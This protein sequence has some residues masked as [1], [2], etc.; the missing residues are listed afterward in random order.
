MYFIAS[1]EEAAK[2]VEETA[3][4][5]DKAAT[6]FTPEKISEYTDMAISGGLKLLAAIAIFF[7]GMWVSKLIRKIVRNSL[8]KREVDATLVSF[9]SSLLYYA[10]MVAVIIAAIQQI[11]FQTTSLVAILG[12]AGL[13]VG[14]ALQGSLSN[15]ASG[16]LIILFRPFQVGDVI[17][18]AGT[19]GSVKDIG[20]LV[21]TLHSP[22]NKK[23]IIPN[24][25]VMGG[26]ITNITSEATRRVDMTVGVSYS[27][28][29]DKVEGIILDVLKADE[30]VLGDPE[31]QV[32][33]G[34]L[35]DNSV[36]FTVRP[37]CKK[38]DYW[39]V[40]FDFQKTIK[41]RLDEEGVS[42]PFPQQDVYMH[43]VS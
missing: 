11:G 7:I 10:L 38:E 39:G 37:W 3:N 40:F 17:E 36:N 5:A 22:D 14:L 29:L 35:A 23:I 42:I 30:R 4:A 2:A 21:T 8:T 18:A 26:T 34:E 31:P 28:D 13:A 1:T 24:S 43:Q 25:A 19:V 41:Q 6:Y 15:F 32:V 9:G 33:V 16:V 20:I 12:A 27:D